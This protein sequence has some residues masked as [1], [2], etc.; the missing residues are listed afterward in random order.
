MTKIASCKISYVCVTLPIINLDDKLQAVFLTNNK[1][2]SHI[3]NPETFHLAQNQ[4]IW[5]QSITW[6][7]ITWI[8]AQKKFTLYTFKRLSVS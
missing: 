8:I 7:S 5:W 1:I 6:Q 4:H 3:Y 2:I